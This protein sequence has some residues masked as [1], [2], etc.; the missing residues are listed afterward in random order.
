MSAINIYIL[1]AILVL[2]GIAIAFLS[3][4][5]TNLKDKIDTFDTIHKLQA[6][7]YK[8]SLDET[9]NNY[10]QLYDLFMNVNKMTDLIYQ[11]YKDL[12]EL[13]K[14]QTEIHNKIFEEYKKIVEG[15]KQTVEI[16]KQLLV[17]CNDIDEQH[18]IT[19]D[20]FDQIG[21][22]IADI[23]AKV[24]ELNETLL[25]KTDNYCDFE[26]DGIY[27]NPDNE[28]IFS[29]EDEDYLSTNEPFEEEDEKD[30]V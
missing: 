17:C 4:Q 7:I 26:P 2:D 29:L 13:Q 24:T 19:C 14:T 20:Q 3:Y 18:N 30:D 10:K 23:Y 16:H 9:W 25:E 22:G 11:Q 28:R 12:Y 5:L 8:E 6:Q 21:K 1:T 15:F 27:W